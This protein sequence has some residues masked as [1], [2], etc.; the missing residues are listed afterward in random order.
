MGAHA[1]LGELT[2]AEVP[3]LDDLVQA[4]LAYVYNAKFLAQKAAEHFANLKKKGRIKGSDG[5]NLT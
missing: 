3:I 5:S 2:K 1:V 4:I